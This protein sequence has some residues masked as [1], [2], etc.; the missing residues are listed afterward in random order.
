[1]P[2]KNIVGHGTHAMVHT[3]CTVHALARE[4][5]MQLL[6]VRVSPYS[7]PRVSGSGFAFTECGRLRKQIIAGA[8]GRK[9]TQ[10]QEQT[11]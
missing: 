7:R 8:L 3:H 2:E 5:I 11:C 1:M 4:N 6:L 9:R 10:T